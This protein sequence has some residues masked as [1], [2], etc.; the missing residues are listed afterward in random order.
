MIRASFT[1][2]GPGIS[3]N[4]LKRVFDPFYTSKEV[5]EGTG[6]GLSICFGIVQ[7]HGGYLY[8]K[9]KRGRGTTFVVEI[10]IVSGDVVADKQND[11]IGSREVKNG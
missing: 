6:L 2:D 9:S 3:E 8:A 11:Q 1:D 5:G 4:D 10:P 7:E